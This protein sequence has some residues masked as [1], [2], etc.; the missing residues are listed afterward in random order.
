MD[1]AIPRDIPLFKVDTPVSFYI[2]R[3][4]AI[5]GYIACLIIRVDIELILTY[6]VIILLYLL[7]TWYTKIEV[8]KDHF[9]LIRIG[10]FYKNFKKEELFEY[11]YISGF[12]FTKSEFNSVVAIISI[13]VPKTP[14]GGFRSPEINFDYKD[15]DGE[16]YAMDIQFHFLE[17]NFAKAFEIINSKIPGKK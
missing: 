11:K 1:K 2:I 17:S 8:L 13:L 3:I 16:T 9:K 6:S 4:V 5:F 14:I 15:I 12:E 7:S 10:P